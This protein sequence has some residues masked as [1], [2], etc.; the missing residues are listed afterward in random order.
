MAVCVI[1]GIKSSKPAL[2]ICANKNMDDTDVLQFMKRPQ[3]T[4]S[5]DCSLWEQPH[6]ELAVMKMQ[7]CYILRPHKPTYHYS[8]YQCNRDLKKVPETKYYIEKSILGWRDDWLSKELFVQAWG[9]EF[10]SLSIDIKSW[11]KACICNPSGGG[12]RDRWVCFS[13]QILQSFGI[14]QQSGLGITASRFHALAP[15]GAFSRDTDLPPIAWTVTP[16]PGNWLKS[17]TDKLACL[18]ADPAMCG[19]LQSRLSDPWA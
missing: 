9:P 6:D 11:L 5:L 19:G 14:F 8:V 16:F 1:L 18:G 17:L 4:S 7:P 10:G 15:K 12:G 3:W 2:Q 13:K